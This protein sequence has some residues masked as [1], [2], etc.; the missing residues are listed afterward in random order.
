MNLSKLEYF[1][2]AARKGSF[3]AAAEE[4]YISQTAVSQQIAALERELGVTLFHR[5]K[6]RVKLTEAGRCLEEEAQ[7]LL[8]RYQLLL[9]RVGRYADRAGLRVEYAGPVEKTILADMVARFSSRCPS[10]PVRL[11]YETQAGACRNLMAGRCD[12]VAAAA[13]EFE[14]EKVGRAVLVRN[15]IRVAVSA[16]GPLA[17]RSS[18]SV[19]DLAGE[20]AVILSR[21][22]AARGHDHVRELLLRLGFRPDQLREAD[23]IESQ[24]FQVELGQG[25]TLLPDVPEVRSGQITLIPFRGAELWHEIDLFYREE[26]PEIRKFLALIPKTE[27]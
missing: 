25:I 3:T 8:E 9:D 4:H 20:Q 23:N 15:P 22:A 26:T 11:R 5:E 17:Q 14:G 13:D 19:E 2:S 18:L 27:D 16:R 1:L 24:I 6:G 7:A 12:L 21:A 10:V